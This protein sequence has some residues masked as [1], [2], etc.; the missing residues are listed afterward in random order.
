LDKKL[1]QR[2]HFPSVNWNISYTNYNDVLEPYF[3][4]I[5]PQFGYLKSKFKNILQTEDELNDIVQL[6]GKD[7]LSE[8][9]KCT[10]FIA[11]IIREDFLKQNA[12]SAHDYYCPLYKTIGMMKCV[13]AFY[14]KAM[15]MI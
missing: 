13:V 14:D 6:V 1:A 5:D 10:L 2:K 7:S 11:G 12:F 4:Q 15:K 8:D 3:N 9:Q